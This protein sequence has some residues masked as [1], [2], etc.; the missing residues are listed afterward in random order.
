MCKVFTI[1]D[2]NQDF[3]AF[4]VIKGTDLFYVLFLVILSYW[5]PMLLYH[6][7]KKFIFGYFF[8]YYEHFCKTEQGIKKI[9]KLKIKFYSLLYLLVEFFLLSFAIVC[10]CYPFFFFFV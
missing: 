6:Y 9:L 4:M 7:V 2:L 3:V 1:A 10:F 5:L 8:V